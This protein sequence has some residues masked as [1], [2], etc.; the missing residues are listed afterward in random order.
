MNI[1]RSVLSALAAVCLLTASAAA[2]FVMCD[3]TLSSVDSGVAHNVES[4]GR[5]ANWAGVSSVSQFTDERGRFCFAVDR[6]D[7]VEICRTENGRVLADETVTVANP[8]T[9]FGGAVCGADGSLY[10]V[11]GRENEGSDTSLSTVFVS[12]HSADGALIATAGGNGKEGL[13][14]YYDEGFYTK[15]PFDAGNCDV[16]INGKVLM[17]NYARKM[18][19]GHQSNT[20][21]AVSTDTMAVIDGFVCYNSHSFD[22]RVSPYGDGFVLAS[23][24]DCFPRSF[25]V[26]TTSAAKSGKAMDFFHFW[27]EADA[28]ANYNMRQLNKTRARL[29]NVLATDAG[30]ALIGASARSL[31]EK[32]D[33]EPYDVFVQVYDPTRGVFLTEGERSGLGGNNGD[34]QV[35]D[36]GVLWLTDLGDGGKTADTVQAVNI[37]GGKIAVLYELSRKGTY[38]SVYDS[39]WLA[40]LNAD[41]SVFQEPMPL[42]TVRLNVDEDPVYADGAV[43]WVSNG[44]GSSLRVNRLDIVTAQ[45]GTLGGALTWAYLNGRVAIIDG[46]WSAADTLLAAAYD[47]DGRLLRAAALDGGETDV[48][49]DAAA[50]KLFRLDGTGAPD[51][52]AA[53]VR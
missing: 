23:Q 28:Y 44:S 40:V 38:G 9:R 37:G 14:Y 39:T 42:G 20:V 43:Y 7:R 34:Q 30:V 48:P 24:G 26:L 8:Y 12:K 51:C 46:T 45:T 15:K 11:W 10:L 18:Y 2:E 33:A 35:T 41:G 36:E 6:G 50:L 52:E 16:A 21:F 53:A 1:K 17:V 5:Y 29:G 4:V 49:E 32:A 22:Q 47:S 19:S 3:A 27:V 13:A 25:S 31:S